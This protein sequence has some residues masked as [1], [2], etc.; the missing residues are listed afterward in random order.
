[1]D[2]ESVKELLRHLSR[3][4]ELEEEELQDLLQEETA[5][6]ESWLDWGLSKFEEV[7]PAI[8]EFAPMLLAAL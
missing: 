5:E 7:L 8:L 3:A 6:T 1:M 4:L 2:Q